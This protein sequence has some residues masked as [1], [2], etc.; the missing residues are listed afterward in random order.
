VGFTAVLIAGIA[1]ALRKVMLQNQVCVPK[2]MHAILPL[3][4]PNHPPGLCNHW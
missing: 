4:F 3:P 1:G 2:K